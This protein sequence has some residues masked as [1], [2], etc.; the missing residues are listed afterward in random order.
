MSSCIS[1]PSQETAVE[2]TDTPKPI[3]ADTPSPTNTPEIKTVI[4]GESESIDGSWTAIISLTTQ[5]RDKKLDFRVS[6]KSENK[7]WIIEQTEWNEIQTSSSMVPFPYI[8]QWSQ[9][10]NHLY[11]SYLPNFNDGC[12]GYFRPGGFD[13][14]QLDLITGEITTVRSGGSTW[15]ALS[16]DEKQLAYIDT[17]SG[18]VSI[19]DIENKTEKTF[20]LPSIENEMEFVTDTSNLYWAPDGKSLVYAHFIG[21]CDMIVPISYI[22]Q[23]YPDTGQQKVLVNQ[24]EDGLYPI[25]WNIQDNILIK[26]S[27]GEMFWLSPLTLEV[28][29][30]VN[31]YIPE[32]S[33]SPNE[34]W[35]GL[36][37][38]MTKEENK[39]LLFKVS[40]NL[41][42]QDWVIEDL[43]FKEL[44][45]MI[46]YYYP[47]IF[48]W[49]DNGSYLFYSHLTTGGDA[50]AILTKPAGYDFKRFDLTNGEDVT[51]Q[52]GWTVWRAL[53]PDESKISYIND[54]GG[55]TILEIENGE[56][57]IFSLPSIEV[58]YGL[59][60]RTS[61]IYWSP[62]GKRL[63]YTYILGFCDRNVYTYILEIDLATQ[64]QS[65][66]VNHDEHGYIPIEWNKQ[67]KILLLDN[68]DNNWW[69]D[70]TTQEITPAE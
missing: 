68:E 1:T 53:S 42:N 2:S 29:P 17:F 59:E 3:P 67:N 33:K 41:T 21:A 25:E 28:I 45:P 36:V 58:E 70:P 54:D 32:N 40:N 30:Y 66:L 19:L 34:N 62:D 20:Q 52:D 15:M 16:P 26:N 35:T 27:N 65:V 22:I 8:F 4:L 14:K 39:K 18:S 47:Y 31:L 23:L 37:T 46:G 60:K 69:L 6:S 48:K 9:D 49:S 63:I 13:L 56:E 50:C 11:F 57:Y 61:Q 51:I 44:E 38:I 10:N 12:F 24:S 55:V 5:E 7:E 43:D 64:K